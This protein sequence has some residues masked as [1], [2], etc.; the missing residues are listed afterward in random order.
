MS[1]I[2]QLESFFDP[3][4]V[5]IIG[6]RRVSGAGSFNVMENMM[7]FGYEGE[8]YPVNPKADEIL[9]K[10]AYSHVSEID[11]NIDHAIIFL[12]RHLVYDNVEACAEQGIGAITIVSQGF[13][14]AGAEGAKMQRGLEELVEDYDIRINGPNTMGTHNFV[15]NFTTAF[16]PISHRDYDPIGV[17]S[18]TGLFSMS[19]PELRYAKYLDLGNACDVDHVDLLKYFG[20]DPEIEQIFLHIEGL[21]ENSGKDFIEAA[22]ETVEEKGKPVLSLKVGESEKG[23]KKAESHTGSL[24]GDNKVYEGAFRKARVT[25]VKDYTD[26]QVVS[27]ALLE[28]PQMDG[29]ELGMITHHGAASIMF[30]DALEEF[31]M[32]LADIKD[33]TV[34]AV[35]KMS[36]DWLDITNPID[37]GP[38]TLGGP[39]KAHKISIEAALEDE[40][41]DALLL[42]VHIT[43]PSPWPMGTWGHIDVLE[44]L[45][46]KYDK[47]VIVV[48][49]GTEQSESKAKIAEIENVIAVGDIRQAVR[50]FSAVADFSSHVKRGE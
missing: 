37:I 42:S 26:A 34:E 12:P 36:P 21:Q 1:V 33:E 35:E 2:E 6:A 17:V 9:G 23:K 41:F 20:E 32:Q 47:P 24:V 49:V 3:S 48:P 5:A 22:R 4:S 25:R 44:E 43:D 39:P 29:D 15:D 38:A 7:D 10:K 11:E 40:N 19:F 16:A 30:M 8:I 14:D 31:G 50:A 13:A 18:Q 27:K 28:L 45:A 46:P